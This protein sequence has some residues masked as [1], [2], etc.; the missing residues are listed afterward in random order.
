MKAV[1]NLYSQS[2]APLLNLWIP[3][4]TLSHFLERVM[5]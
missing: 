2:E 1:A 5:L 3:H 4:A